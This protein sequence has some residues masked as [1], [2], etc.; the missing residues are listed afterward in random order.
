[1][2]VI[3]AGSRTVTDYEF[4]KKVIEASGFRIT[5]VV[6][7]MANGV[8]LL[9]KRWAEENNI[10]VDKFPAKWKLYGKSAGYK[11]NVEMAENAD[12]LIAIQQ[13]NSPGTMHMINI[14][15]EKG[16]GAYIYT[17]NTNKENENEPKGK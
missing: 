15:K 10:P 12:A 14:A 8:D 7:G 17:F 16:L 3:I 11:R 9:G 13:N 1:M 6:C 5:R 2:R 4:V